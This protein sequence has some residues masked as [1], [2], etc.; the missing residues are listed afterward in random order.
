MLAVQSTPH[1]IINVIGSPP[2]LDFRGCLW[3]TACDLQRLGGPPLPTE[4]LVSKSF[5]DSYRLQMLKSPNFGHDDMPGKQWWEEAVRS[6]FL[7][8][9]MLPYFYDSFDE[10]YGEAF[11]GSRGVEG[12]GFWKRNEGAVEA[13]ASVAGRG[14][15]VGVISNSDSRYHALLTN[16]GLAE[17]IDFVH[18]SGETGWK[19]P[20]EYAFH[21]AIEAASELRGESV[22]ASEAVHVGMSASGDVLGA[23]EAGWDA[24]YCGDAEM[25]IDGVVA[26]PRRQIAGL[27]AALGLPAD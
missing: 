13:L 24:V 22:L 12:G 11:D 7:H 21:T 5:H 6:T 8:T 18:V 26:L 9:G 2:Q 17:H 19:K 27:G 15:T 1:F 14:V 23:L 25:A 16:L 10:I 3:Q 20:E 4:D